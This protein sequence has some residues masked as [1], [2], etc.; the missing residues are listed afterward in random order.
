[1]KPF[2][3]TTLVGEP[4][5]PFTGEPSSELERR[6]SRLAF[7]NPTVGAVLDLGRSLH[8]SPYDRMVLLAYTF[9]GIHQQMTIQMLETVTF[10]SPAPIVL[11]SNSVHDGV[12]KA[13]AGPPQSPQEN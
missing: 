11:P 6:I 1:M 13:A 10:Q 2:M 8:I 4:L 9:I 7:D 5:P 12:S 3:N